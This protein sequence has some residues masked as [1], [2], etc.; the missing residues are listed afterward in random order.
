MNASRPKL[1]VIFLPLESGWKRDKH[2]L[3]H[4]YRRSERWDQIVPNLPPDLYQRAL[5]AGCECIDRIQRSSTQHERL[6]E[7]CRQMVRADH[8]AYYRPAYEHAASTAQERGKMGPLGQDRLFL[9][10]ANGVLVIG[11]KAIG[12]K[13]PRVLTAYRPV[14]SHPEQRTPEEI[15]TLADHL[16]ETK[17]ALVAA[18][19]DDDMEET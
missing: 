18:S 14:M 19:E 1:F 5:K 9:A 6:P 10:G 15:A 12:E 13:K 7:A 8:D 17:T 16:W 3:K 2:V 4:L 11:L